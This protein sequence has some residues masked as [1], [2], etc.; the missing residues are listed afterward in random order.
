MPPIITQL[1]VRLPEM[2]SAFLESQGA[3]RTRPREI[4]SE[5]KS[6]QAESPI[7]EKKHH[8]MTTDP[9]CL[10]APSTCLQYQPLRRPPRRLSRAEQ[11]PNSTNPAVSTTT[12]AH[13]KRITKCMSLVLRSEVCKFRTSLGILSLIL[14]FGCWNTDISMVGLRPYTENTNNNKHDKLRES[15]TPDQDLETSRADGVELG[16]LYYCCVIASVRPLA[17]FFCEC[18]AS[19]N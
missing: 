17:H 14:F 13:V 16:A 5:R 11:R 10:P 3:E 4:L 9:K 18:H 15:E 2:I 7:T 12:S 19:E 1:V 8:P 6:I